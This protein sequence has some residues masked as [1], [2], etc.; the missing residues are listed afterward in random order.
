MSEIIQ[1]PLPNGEFVAVE[2]ERREHLR[3]CFRKEMQ[4]YVYVVEFSSGT[5]KVGKSANV[6]QRLR[7]HAKDALNHGITIVRSWQSPAHT[8]W[9]ENE[10][11]LIAFCWEQFGHPVSGDEYFT[12]ADFPVIAQYA[13]ELTFP[14]LR[15]EDLDLSVAE[16]AFMEQRPARELAEQQRLN[17]IEAGLPEDYSPSQAAIDW[18]SSLP[19]A[20][21]EE[22]GAAIRHRLAREGWLERKEQRKRMREIEAQLEAA[23]RS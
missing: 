8:T 4:G 6:G 7:Q 1:M 23:G 17:R 22:I 5:I 20:Q 18:F 15:A 2:Q 9:S 19:E 21:A 11:A 13:S 10:Q 14:A 3:R 12:D 16:Y